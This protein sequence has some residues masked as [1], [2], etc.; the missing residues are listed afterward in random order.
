[1]EE[2]GALCWGVRG[3]HWSTV[4]TD[5]LGSVADAW[6]LLLAALRSSPSKDS[7]TCRIGSS[8]VQRR[9]K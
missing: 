8:E 5:L 3:E 2:G 6:Q 7:P 4:T 9:E 1:M